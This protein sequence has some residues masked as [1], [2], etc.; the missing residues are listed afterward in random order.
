MKIARILLS[1]Y[2]NVGGIVGSTWATGILIATKLNDMVGTYRD[3]VYRILIFTS[4]D[5]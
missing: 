3:R 1:L 2:E 4:T 5:I